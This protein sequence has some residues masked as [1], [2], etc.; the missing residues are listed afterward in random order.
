M[1]PTPLF[2]GDAKIGPGLGPKSNMQGAPDRYQFHR[3]I[4]PGTPLPRSPR[5]LRTGAPMSLKSYQRNWGFPGG[6]SVPSSCD[7]RLSGP[8]SDGSTPTCV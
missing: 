1:P 4:R 8:S 7:F 2:A 3:D 6:L 5:V